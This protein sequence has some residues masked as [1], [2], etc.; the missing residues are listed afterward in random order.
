MIESRCFLVGSPRSGTTLLQSMLAVHPD[1]T[2]FPETNFVNAVVGD[3]QRRVIQRPETSQLRKLR[4]SARLALGLASRNTV[5][6]FR[7]VMR[8]LGREELGSELSGWP[9]TIERAI[10]TL[11]RSLDRIA[12]DEGN[13]V[14]INKTP[15]YFA[16][17]DYLERYCADARV[18]H[19]VRPGAEVVASLTDA[20]RRY[21]DSFWVRDFSDVKNC[22]RCWNAAVKVA[23]ANRHRANHYVVRF[24]TF[25]AEPDKHMRALCDWLKLDFEPQ[26]LTAYHTEAARLTL[27]SEKWK[28]GAAAPISRVNKFERLFDAAERAAIEAQLEP[29]DALVT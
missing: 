17:L 22:I 29:L 12:E 9:V 18:V 3:F 20:A 24:D 28:A 2:S 13:S 5:P 23:K 11:I 1:V 14:W 4:T 6:R 8:N 27:G 26:M 19:L 25:L 7:R 15:T 10:R 16:Y 21:P